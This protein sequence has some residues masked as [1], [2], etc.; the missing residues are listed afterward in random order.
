MDILTHAGVGLIAASPFLANSP[1]LAL[2]LVAG[3]VL[4]DLDALSRLVNKR[5]FL[6]AHQTW[7]H[8]LPIQLAFCLGLGAIAAWFGLR[9][10]ELGG[11]LS[12]GLTGH[13][14]LDLSNTYGVTLWSPF[15]R[16]RFCLEWVFFIDAVVLAA[17]SAGLLVVVPV[18]VRGQSVPLVY[19]AASLGFLGVYVLAKGALRRRAGRAAPQARS[20]VPSALV[21][22][23]FY[24]TAR[25]QASLMIFRV[26]ALTGTRAQ[27]AEVALFDADYEDVL[28]TV[29]DFRLMRELS[30]D[31]HVVS[32]STQS[33]HTRLLCRDMRT[34]NFGTRFGDLEVWLDSSR[35]IIRSQFHV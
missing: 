32:T 12:A 9:G 30:P 17:I 18:L 5:A 6:H 2:G 25:E 19:P 15:S 8:A 1:E 23:R 4:P 24:G 22:W 26:N 29:A 35:Q 34:R 31:Y 10:A 33:S 7:S 28:Q 27:V 11:G 20:L 21:P 13:S 14:L 3:S 16:R